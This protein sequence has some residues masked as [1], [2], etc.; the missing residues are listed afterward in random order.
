MVPVKDR[1]KVPLTKALHSIH[2]VPWA[3]QNCLLTRFE[4]KTANRPLVKV[5]RRISRLRQARLL[6]RA[7]SPGRL[8]EIQGWARK[9]ESSLA[10]RR[11]QLP[12]PGISG[13]VLC[14]LTPG[15]A[16]SDVVA[17]RFLSRSR[18]H[19]LNRQITEHKP[20]TVP[21]DVC[22]R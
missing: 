8:C 19:A 11:A 14:A 13:V 10:G 1:H 2:M 4:E 16:S 6:W 5:S 15:S 7:L 22:V 9:K 3:Y 20:P 21:L 17:S 18:A 12:A